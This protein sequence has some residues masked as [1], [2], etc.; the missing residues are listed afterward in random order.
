MASRFA[1]TGAFGWLIAS[2]AACSDSSVQQPQP[3]SVLVAVEV[4]DDAKT[5]PFDE[6]RSVRVPPGFGFRVVARVPSSRFVAETPE[7]DLLVSKPG[8]RAESNGQIFRISDL[9]ATPTVTEVASGLTLPHDLVFKRIGNTTYLYVSE[10]SRV[11]RVPWSEGPVRVGALE[12]VV[13]DLPS[14]SLPELQGSY[15]HALK[16]IALTDEMLFV[17][18]ASA[19]NAD[20]S[21]VLADPVRGAI[22]AYDLDGNGGR[23][24]ATGVRNAEGLAIHPRTG[25]LW[26]AGNH[27][28]NVR[29]P[30]RDGRYPYGDLNQEYVNDNPPEPFTHIRDG[31]NYGWP[32]C[33]PSADDGPDDLPYH[34]DVDNNP[35]ESVLDCAAIDRT[36]KA[37]PAH[38][39]PLGLSFWS[40]ESVPYE[41]RDG[42]VI[43]MHGCWNCSIPKGY[44]VV[45]L[46]LRADDQ[47]DDP[48]DLVS[49]FIKDPT[50]KDTAWGRPVDVIP[51]RRGGLFIS[52]DHAGAIYEL[53]KK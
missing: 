48:M 11:S 52:D 29:Y 20:P 3:A 2:A 22:Y 36:S 44:K 34:H 39:A 19:T 45:F 35:D 42:A 53:Y 43:G 47:F 24:Y 27:R 15:G 21:D 40:G 25:E 50:N 51:N 41:Y 18:I 38:S 1:S 26:V 10:H 23:L 13:R 4:P 6:P 31:G 8:A 5:A 9:D 12:P 33:N 37:L 16:N 46:P 32:Y 17:S 28:D 30:L 7:G 49:G 14:A